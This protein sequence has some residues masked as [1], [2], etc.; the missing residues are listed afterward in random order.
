[1]KHLAKIAAAL[2]AAVVSQSS[3]AQEKGLLE[4]KN[5]VLTEIRQ[6]AKPGEQPKVELVPAVT[7]LPGTELVYR[8]SYR[9]VGAKA[10]DNVVLNSPV[11]KDLSYRQAFALNAAPTVSTDGKTFGELAKLTVA[12]AD[13]NP[14]PAQND[15]VVAVRW[16]LSGSVKPG[17]AGSVS[18]RAVVK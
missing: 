7:I 4:V 3:L 1:M 12:G 14:R 5:E 17:E 11:P 18:F 8:V 16:V 15:D 6:P 2:V 10:A 9:N 13:G